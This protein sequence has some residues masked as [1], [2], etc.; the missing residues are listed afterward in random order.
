MRKN[1]SIGKSGGKYSY[2]SLIQFLRSTLRTSPKFLFLF[3]EGVERRLLTLSNS[4]V[5]LPPDDGK[6]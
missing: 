4:M 6:G 2:N 1:G 5:S 3:K